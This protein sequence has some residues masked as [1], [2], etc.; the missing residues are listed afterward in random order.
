MA[1]QDFYGTWDVR[2]TSGT[3]FENG[4]QIRIEESNDSS[5]GDLLPERVPVQVLFPNRT[6]TGFYDSSTEAIQVGDPPSPAAATYIS[7]YFDENQVYKAIYGITIGAGCDPTVAVW[8]ADR[9]SASG[10]EASGSAIDPPP[11]SSYDGPY[12]VKAGSAFP[13]ESRLSLSDRA[14]RLTVTDDSGVAVLALDSLIYNLPTVSLEGV[15][16]P[17]DLLYLWSLA[18]F[19]SKRFIY[20]LSIKESVG[21]DDWPEQAGAC[22]A[23]EEPPPRP[24]DTCR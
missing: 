18:T 14:S 1:V 21:A 24:D 22:G 19:D 6:V 7:R 16:P 9:K 10:P 5:P 17:R 23:E 8:G 2:L 12:T 4:S 11:L 20:G 13:M 3:P 15:D